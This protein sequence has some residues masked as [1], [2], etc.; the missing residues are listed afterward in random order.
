MTEKSV[1]AFFAAIMSSP[2]VKAL[3]LLD[4]EGARLCVNY[5]NNSGYS[6]LASQ[7]VFENSLFSKVKSSRGDSMCPS[8]MHSSHS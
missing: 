2:S 3:F 4:S 8:T 5:Y 7:R 1:I 6:S